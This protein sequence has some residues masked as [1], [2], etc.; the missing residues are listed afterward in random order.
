VINSEKSMPNLGLATGEQDI[1][2]FD[3]GAPF[4]SL[5]LLY[6][7]CGLWTAA[8]NLNCAATNLEI[9]S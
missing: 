7:R 6:F 5:S 3:L 8:Y 9:Q 4:F 2:I 1:S